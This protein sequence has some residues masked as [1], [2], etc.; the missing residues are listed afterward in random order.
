MKD[1]LLDENGDLDV[2]NGLQLT[3]SDFQHQEDLLVAG[4]TEWKESPDTGVGL[5]DYLNESE[6]NNMLLEVRS[7]FQ[8]DGMTVKSVAYDETTGDLT[9]DAKYNN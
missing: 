8:N 4:K 6:V 1:L 5:Y 9:Y 2:G 7:E 3:D